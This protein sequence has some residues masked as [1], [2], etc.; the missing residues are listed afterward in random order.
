MTACKLCVFIKLSLTLYYRDGEK[1][2]H[3][4][5]WQQVDNK[6]LLHSFEYFSLTEDI[7]LVVVGDDDVEC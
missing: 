6:W 7:Y 1:S 4:T 5:T 2:G 3:T